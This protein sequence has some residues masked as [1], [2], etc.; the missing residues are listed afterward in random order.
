MHKRC[1]ATCSFQR[2]QP[3]LQQHRKLSSSGPRSPATQTF[4]RLLRLSSPHSWRAVQHLSW[5]TPTSQRPSRLIRPTCTKDLVR[6]GPCDPA[7]RTA[8]SCHD[9]QTHSPSTIVL[10][11]AVKDCFACNLAH[12]LSQLHLELLHASGEGAAVAGGTQGQPAEEILWSYM[13][14]L[15]SAA[16]AA[17]SAGLL[18][19]PQSL[20]PC[21]VILTSPR[22]I[23]VGE[24]PSTSLQ[25]A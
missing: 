19:R 6:P 1:G 2:T 7:N 12:A 5:C 15:T 14:Q 8:L 17:H 13:V 9:W 4:Q 3:W 16:R 25:P 11:H 21:K 23:R 20:T 22:R 24:L 10:R 18:L